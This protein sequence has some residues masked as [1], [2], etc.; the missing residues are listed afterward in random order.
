[1]NPDV[2][3][4]IAFSGIALAAAIVFLLAVVPQLR[5]ESRRAQRLESSRGSAAGETR[6][7]AAAR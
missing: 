6:Q 4:T 1:M 2:F 3:I 5:R 7:R